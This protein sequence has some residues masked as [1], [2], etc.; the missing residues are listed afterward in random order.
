MNVRYGVETYLVGTVRRYVLAHFPARVAAAQWAVG[1]LSEGGTCGTVLGLAHPSTYRTILDL[2]GLADPI[3]EHDTIAQSLPV[4]F[5]GSRAEFDR[6]DPPWL[7]RH[8]DY[9]GVG[10][11]FGCGTADSASRAAQDELAPLGRA[12]GLRVSVHTYP[13]GH[14]WSVW[15]AALREFLPWFW[16]RTDGG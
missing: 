8:R 14:A 5:G 1:G 16:A 7:L 4:L 12:A 11:W 10:A 3:Y 9:R 6:H 15:T 2:S 13:G